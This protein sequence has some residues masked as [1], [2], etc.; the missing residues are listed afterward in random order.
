M[1]ICKKQ[2]ERVTVYKIDGGGRGAVIVSKSD[3]HICDG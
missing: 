1:H 2:G 3:K